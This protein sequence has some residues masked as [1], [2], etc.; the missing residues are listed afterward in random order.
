[1]R[2]E[3]E[4]G[5]RSPD[6]G[7]G[8][9]P[10]MLTTRF[11]FCWEGAGTPSQ[12]PYEAIEGEYVVRSYGLQWMTAS[13]CMKKWSGRRDSNPRRPAWE[14]GILPLNYSRPGGWTRRF[15][16]IATSTDATTYED[17]IS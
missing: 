2:I 9:R 17:S 13:K 11:W 12:P 15:Y 5:T 4:S 3:F 8:A 1:M 7:F 6:A 10:G 16:Q 14:A